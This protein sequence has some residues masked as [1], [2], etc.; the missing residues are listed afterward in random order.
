M[1]IFNEFPYTNIHELNLDWII[2][3]VKNVLAEWLS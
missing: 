2:K 3:E 1:S